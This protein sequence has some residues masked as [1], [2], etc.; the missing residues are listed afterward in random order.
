MSRQSSKDDQCTSERS[1]ASAR[2]CVRRGRSEGTPVRR[3]SNQSV[4]DTYTAMGFSGPV[5]R[6][7]KAQTLD[8]VKRR[9]QHEY[10]RFDAWYSGGAE[11]EKAHQGSAQ[12]RIVATMRRVWEMR[13]N[14]ARY[15]PCHVPRFNRP[16]VMGTWILD[17]K[18]AFLV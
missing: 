9:R 14:S 8:S 16:F 5:S 11:V 15:M 17:P 4:P 13:R 2:V 6:L 10:C 12:G 1:K 18:R 3:P 7:E